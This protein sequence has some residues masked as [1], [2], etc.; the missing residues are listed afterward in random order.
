MAKNHLLTAENREYVLGQAVEHYSA[1]EF[2]R[3]AQLL[4]GYIVLDESDARPWQLLGSV[5]LLQNRHGEALAA[6]SKAH[7]LLPDEPYT[8]VALAEI[9]LSTLH[10]DTAAAHLKR[11]FELDPAGVH[12]AANRGRMLLQRAKG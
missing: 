2:D 10:F 11:L 1:G 6:Y 8:L 7:A 3:A 12:P 4:L 5:Y 9:A